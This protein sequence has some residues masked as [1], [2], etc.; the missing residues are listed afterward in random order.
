MHP[1]SLVLAIV[2]TAYCGS[3]WA[4]P[5]TSPQTSKH[6]EQM[7]NYCQGDYLTYCGNLAPED[8]SLNACFKTNRAKLSENCVRSIEY[9][10]TKQGK[11][12]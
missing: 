3:A 1:A 11:K 7:R 10:Y 12:W 2:L 4:A 6:T 8:P 5:D 9:Y